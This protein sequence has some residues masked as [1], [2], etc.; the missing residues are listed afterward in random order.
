MFDA[1]VVTGGRTA[2][3]VGWRVPFSV[4]KINSALASP[5]EVLSIPSY[6]RSLNMRRRTITVL[7]YSPQ[8]FP[9]ALDGFERLNDKA[10]FHDTASFIIVSLSHDFVRL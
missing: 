6:G 8:I 2:I 3:S 10:N 4:A 5:I 7:R 1:I 9:S